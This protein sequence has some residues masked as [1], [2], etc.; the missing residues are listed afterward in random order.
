MTFRNLR[1]ALAPVVVLAGGLF[2][3]SAAS[4]SITGTLLTGSSGTMTISLANVI[5]NNDSAAVGGGNSDVATGTSLT[6]VGCASGVLGAPG[7]LGLQEGVTINNND[8]TTTP[9]SVANANTFLTFAA[10][11]NLVFSIVSPPGPGSLN[12][13]CATANANGLSCSVFANSPLILTYANGNTFMG[14]GVHGNASDA[15]VGGLATASTYSGGFSEFFTAL[16]PNGTAPTPQNIQLF[17]CP[18]GTCVAADFSS[19]RN[20]TSSQS[21]TFTASLVPEPSS[22]VLSFIGILTLL[23]RMKFRKSYGTRS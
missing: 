9:P 1:L 8:L 13:N 20:I 6:F 16:L 23:V 11:P 17:F 10:H 7:C 18:S 12:T 2:L 22:V 5:F 3:V 21:G 19:S 14:L 15:G 4:A